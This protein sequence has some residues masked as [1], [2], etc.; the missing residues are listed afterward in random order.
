MPFTSRRRVDEV[1]A[2]L[3]RGAF[4]ALVLL[5]ASLRAE[6]RAEKQVAEVP[7]EDIFGF[8][9]PTDVGKPGELEYFNEN[10]G[11]VGKREG[12]YGALDSRFALG[13][14]FADNWWVAGAFFTAVNQS[15]HVAS[16][17]DVDRIG[18]D[19]LSIELMHRILE[20]SSNNPFAVTLSV[21][22][23][24]GQIDDVTGLPSA[25][26]GSEFK[27]F[28]DSVVIPDKLY[29][30]GNLRYSVLG[31]QDPLAHGQSVFSAQLL[32]STALTWQASS[33]LYFGG[34]LRLFLLSDDWTLSHQTGRALYLGPTML[35]KITD[36]IALNI[37]FQPQLYG[38]SAT[39][40]GLALDLD[41]FERAQFRARLQVSF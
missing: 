36:K 12:T 38:R 10:D 34:E 15:S 32:S 22:P 9:S 33:S 31:A 21:E 37:T 20:R 28:T 35:W 17:P 40:P 6:D 24:W 25:S 1:R 30:G 19:G 4:V 16:L 29:W 23:R 18:F 14:T 8:T 2:R 3:V 39:N 26:V 41:N 7:G 27:F 11:R 5:P 13:Y